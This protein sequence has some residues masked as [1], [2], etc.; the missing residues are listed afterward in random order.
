MSIKAKA[1][2]EVDKINKELAKSNYPWKAAINPILLL[3]PEERRI[4]SGYVPGPDET[5]YDEKEAKGNANKVEKF[6][7]RAKTSTYPDSF[8][9]RD[10]DNGAYVP[11][12][13]NQGHCNSCT[14]FATT[15]ALTVQAWKTLGKPASPVPSNQAQLS[16]AYLYY[17]I[18]EAQQGRTCSNG[19]WPS[20]AIDAVIS[21]GCPYEYY[22]PYTAGD[23]SCGVKTPWTG[24]KAGSRQTIKETTQMKDYISGTAPLVA[25]FK[26]YADFQSYSSGVYKHPSGGS[27]AIHNVCVL[28]YDDNQAAWLCQNSY[29]SG[30]GMDGYFWI[31]YGQ[32]GIDGYMYAIN[33]ITNTTSSS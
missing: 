9:W 5:S 17:C 1:E 10:E 14:T 7:S 6:F 16:P 15:G 30:W 32:C 28:G 13:R 12:V 8:D 20:H 26:E 3:E 24:V 19:W 23:Q 27:Y 4:I 18:A 22:F 2:A 21:D 11:A 33:D 29:G 25:F 31:G